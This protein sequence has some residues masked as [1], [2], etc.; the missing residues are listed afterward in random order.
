MALG[1]FKVQV[2]SDGS[3]STL[4]GLNNL[5]IFIDY[6]TFY[7][8]NCYLQNVE[9][10]VVLYNVTNLAMDEDV[11]DEKRSNSWYSMANRRNQSL[12]ALQTIIKQKSTNDQVTREMF[13]QL[14]SQQVFYCFQV[15]KLAIRK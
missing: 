15:H 13:C 14:F 6:S 3:T 11:E 10:S 9:D 7:I 5:S 8:S 2:I 4:V 12:T 1:R